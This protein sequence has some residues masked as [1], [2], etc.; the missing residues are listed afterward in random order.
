MHF[1]YMVRALMHACVGCK[2][3]SVCGVMVEFMVI[4]IVM[5]EIIIVMIICT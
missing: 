3:V 2:D 5:K 1:E 4:M